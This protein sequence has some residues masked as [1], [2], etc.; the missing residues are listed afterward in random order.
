MIA[1]LDRITHSI[2]RYYNV[3]TERS[4]DMTCCLSFHH[5]I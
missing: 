3:A 2:F 5:P 4:A 1:Q